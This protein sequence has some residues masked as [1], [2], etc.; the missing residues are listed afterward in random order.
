MPSELC[1]VSSDR[2]KSF[3]SINLE[4]VLGESLQHYGF[5]RTVPFIVNFE[6]TDTKRAILSVH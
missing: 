4:G 3:Y 6:V 2:E 5:K 1:A